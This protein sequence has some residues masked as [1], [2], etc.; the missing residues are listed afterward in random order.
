MGMYDSVAD[1][2]EYPDERLS[3][4]LDACAA[5]L[6]DAAATNLIAAFRAQVEQ[7]GVARLQELY[8]S[9]FDM[10]AD[11]ALYVGHH[12][13]GADARRGVFMACLA[14]EYRKAGIECAPE[15]PDYLP[16]VLRY[17]ERAP[18][19]TAGAREELVA[20]VVLPATRKLSETLDRRHHPYA[21][22]MHALLIAL[23]AAHAPVVI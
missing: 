21:L 1:L 20:A 18:G 15:L 4:R 10:D 9:A 3:E 2:L 12:L 8:T 6:E 19:G 7:S 22:V 14:A 23:G 17:I 11:C 16:A 13:F 5:S